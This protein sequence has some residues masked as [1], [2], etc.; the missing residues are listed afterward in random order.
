MIG[1]QN[2]W[3]L[4]AGTLVASLMGCERSP[5]TVTTAANDLAAPPAKSAGPVLFEDATDAFGLH[6]VHD[7]G[8]EGK[9]FMP[10]MVGSGAAL[11][12]YDDDG[13]VDLY[14]LQNAGR[15][16]NS[17]NQLF[18][19]EP[20]GS[21]K[22]ASAASGLDV[23]GQGMGVAIGDVNNDGRP[24]VLVCEYGGVRLFTNNGHGRFTDVAAASALENPRW[25][26]AAAFFDYD[27]D[28]WLDLVVV[29]YVDYDE[30]RRCTGPNGK[31][32][33]C[34]PTAFPGTSARLFRNRCAEGK[35]LFEDVSAKCGL[36][37]SAGAGLGILC[38]DFDGDAWQDIF[39]TNDAGA[40][41]LWINQR[42]GTFKDEAVVRG[43][44]YNAMGRPQ[45]NMGIAFSDIEGDGF[46]DLFVTHLTEEYHALYSQRPQGY[47]QDRTASTG[48]T[49]SHWHGTGFGTVFADFDHD[50]FPDL[51]VVNGRVRRSALVQPPPQVVETLGPFWSLYAEQNQIFWNEGTGR[52]RDVSPGNNAFC[53]TLHVGRGLAWGDLDG[54][55]AVDLV[56]T[57]VAGSARIY[58]NIAPKRGHWLLV[59]AIEPRYGGRDALGAKITLVTTSKRWTNWIVPG[60]SYQCSSDSRAH[61]GLGAVDQL[62]A[63]EVTWPDGSS[64]S[65]PGT[66]A[67]RVVTVR[68]GQ[69]KIVAGRESQ[70]PEARS[71]R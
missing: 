63:I 24:D 50:G 3:I 28:G 47:F 8:P 2:G 68:R 51:A 45:A 48:L 34:G 33:Y 29:N 39:V 27:R 13:R 17:P 43:I 26:C 59:R 52:F 70:D 7:P 20:D 42:D 23:T 40:N 12:D 60:S 57:S 49:G 30:S 38:A 36:S 31:P 62:S 11:F 10:E 67:D 53:Q 64:E 14:L 56:T 19:H 71:P 58:R 66:A 61:F 21:F 15:G 5:Q 41:N 4:A 32:D 35:V 37:T 1:P 46:I 55:G 6:F 18:H 44:A 25:A 16:S 69:G 22:N 65:F 9:F 54:D